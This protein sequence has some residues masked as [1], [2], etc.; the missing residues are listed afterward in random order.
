MET[1]KPSNMIKNHKLAKHIS[2]AS[3]YE[4]TRQV[5]YKSLWYNKELIKVSQW[6]P[7]SQICSTCGH[8]DGK[9][10]L[11][12]REWTCPNCGT[13]HERDINASVNILNE[14]LRLYT[15]GTTV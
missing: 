8:N 6:Y 11:S 2:D 3:W 13:V 4:F 1:L 15:V 9:K 7:S 14:G 5:Q 12:I 10:G